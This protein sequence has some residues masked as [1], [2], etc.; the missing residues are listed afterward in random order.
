MIYDAYCIDDK[1]GRACGIMEKRK[2]KCE[3]LVGKPGGGGGEREMTELLGIDRRMILK[4]ILNAVGGHG[5]C[6][7]ALEWS[8]GGL[9]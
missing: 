3:V 2:N 9:L 6:K 8:S 7:L 4:W 5:L 1:I